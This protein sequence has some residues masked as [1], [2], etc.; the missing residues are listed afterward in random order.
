MDDEP[1]DPERP[2][3]RLLRITFPDGRYQVRTPNDLRHEKESTGERMPG[4]Q[5]GPGRPSKTIPTL[6]VTALYVMDVATEVLE[7]FRVALSHFTGERREAALEMIC[8]IVLARAP[9]ASPR[10]L[11]QSG[12]MSR[13]TYYRWRKEGQVFLD[14]LDRI[15]SQPTRI[16]NKID[17]SMTTNDIRAIQLFRAMGELK[18]DAD[19]ELDSE[20]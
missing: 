5:I 11:A 10:V 9:S 14:Q 8:K 20:P 7:E 13:A 2:E 12:A 17:H 1:V 18:D 3:N 16:E 15:E 6:D 19:L 4:E